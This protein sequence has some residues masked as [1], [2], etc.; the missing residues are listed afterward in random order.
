VVKCKVSNKLKTQENIM[1]KPRDYQ[2]QIKKDL[3]KKLNKGAK[4]V[5]IVAPTGSGKCLGKDTPILMFDGTIKKVQDVR[6]GDLL[7]GDDS[8]P[9]TVL[10]T[11]QG[12]EELFKITPI[13]GEPWVCNRSHILSLVSNSR[14]NGLE[15]GK[16]YD[17]P[18][19]EYLKLDEKVQKSL[20]QYSASVDFPAKKTKFA[21]FLLGCAFGDFT[22]QNEL[23]FGITKDFIPQEYLLNNKFT[24]IELLGGLIDGNKGWIKENSCLL[25]HPNKTI[26]EQIVWL[27][28]SLGFCASISSIILGSTNFFQINLSGDFTKLQT[29]FGQENLESF[30]PIKNMTDFT[31]ESI[32]EGEYY[33]FEIDG[34]RRF[35]LGDFTVTHN[36]VISTDIISDAVSRNRKVLFLIHRD[37]LAEQTAKTLNR[38]GL[39][40]GFIMGKFK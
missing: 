13:K 20:K 24:R 19:V 40:C 5:V 17:V 21:P 1:F 22:R 12:I 6:T 29:F 38:F 32:G 39:N 27:A 11:C 3:Y 2:V 31:V 9:R 10:S 28:K 16:V 37:V 35:L 4:K 23:W 8:T 7:M 34:N 25:I 33:G 26:S 18:L 15:K 30:S 14:R 36:T